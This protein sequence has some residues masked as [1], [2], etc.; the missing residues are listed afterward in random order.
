MMWPQSGQPSKACSVYDTYLS[1]DRPIFH[2]AHYHAFSQLVGWMDERMN[3]WL[4]L[5][6]AHQGPCGVSRARGRELVLQSSPVSM[7]TRYAKCDLNL[8]CPE[9]QTR[10]GVLNSVCS[11]WPQYDHDHGNT[12]ASKFGRCESAGY[13]VQ[14]SCWTS[15]AARQ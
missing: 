2:R 14:P 1:P 7:A 11:V 5:I 15:L 8:D 6:S 3:I 12:V 10:T 13:S 9:N 4:V